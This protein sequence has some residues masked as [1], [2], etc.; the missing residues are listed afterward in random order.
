[1]PSSWPVRSSGA[2]RTGPPDLDALICNVE[3]TMS[4]LRPFAD[5]AWT[6][7]DGT[8]VWITEAEQPLPWGW[9]WR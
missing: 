3:V 6:L 7:E 8:K 1:M 4:D 2:T 5:V 9:A